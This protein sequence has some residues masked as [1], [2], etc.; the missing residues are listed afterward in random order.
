MSVEEIQ[1]DEIRDLLTE[2]VCQQ[3][4]ILARLPPLP[5]IHAHPR[6]KGVDMTNEQGI[7]EA[8]VAYEGVGYAVSITGS[9]PIAPN[10]EDLRGVAQQWLGR[11]EDGEPWQSF[12]VNGDEQ[13]FTV[14]ISPS[15]TA[16]DE[17][18]AGAAKAFL[19]RVDARTK[20]PV[21]PAEPQ[22]HTHVVRTIDVDEYGFVV[23]I[24]N[25]GV[26]S[27][28]LDEADDPLVRRAAAEWVQRVE[29]GMPWHTYAVSVPTPADSEPSD[30]VYAVTITVN[31][32]PDAETVMAAAESFLKNG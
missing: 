5:R 4:E 30:D 20:D 27:H 26:G 1:L 18:A 28:P 6:Y 13:S 22:E 12:T 11:V 3:K 29:D 7:A 24:V 15:T 14:A 32:N 9:G 8:Y 23:E 17:N 19:A 10:D 21:T 2:M 25:T 16:T 31:G